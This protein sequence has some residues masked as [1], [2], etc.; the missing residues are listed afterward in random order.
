MTRE[1]ELA[2]NRGELRVVYKISYPP[3][4]TVIYFRLI[5]AQIKD[6]MCKI[7][8][9]QRNKAKRLVEHFKDVLNCTGSMYAANS[10]PVTGDIEIDSGPP[11]LDEGQKAIKLLKNKL[12]PLMQNCINQTS[13]LP[14]KYSSLFLGVFTIGVMLDIVF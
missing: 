13:T 8:S 5:N 7:L 1:A 3:R 4:D 12:I 14:A 6:K 9:T 10:T 11:T 2:N